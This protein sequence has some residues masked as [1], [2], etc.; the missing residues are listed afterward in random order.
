MQNE[1]KLKITDIIY[2]GL[3][4]VLYVLCY[5]LFYWMALEYQGKYIS[6]LAYYVSLQSSDERVFR[7][8]GLMYKA[9][10]RL[11]P[12][13]SVEGMVAF[14]A[15]MVVLIV[16]TN[17]AY[18]KFFSEESGAH[19]FEIQLASLLGPFMGSMYIPSLHEYF[20]RKSFASF[21]WHSPTYFAMI[22]SGTLCLLFFIKMYE[23][24]KDHISW[25]YWVLT[26]ITGTLSSH[27][28][29]SFI[30]NMIAAMIAVFLI[31][32]VKTPAKERLSTFK[33]LVIMG[34]S[35]VPAGCMVLLLFKIEFRGEGHAHRG[36]I[37][38]TFGNLLNT[39]HLA[40]TAIAGLAFPLIVWIVN[41]KLIKSKRYCMPFGIFVMGICQWAPFEETGARASHGNFDWGLNAGCYYLF[42][43][44][45]AIAINNWHDRENFMKDKPALRNL[46][47]CVLAILLIWHVGSQLVY[48]YLVYHGNHFYQ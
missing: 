26:M 38:I 27:A 34:L 32:L 14:T 11:M 36:G 3:I 22:F 10:Y 48:F 46:Y 37:D 30:L 7:F 12:G 40:I 4:S 42:L 1:S 13:H 8:V 2:I 21:A 47:F 18:I 9:I 23:S 24:S 41:Y 25:K 15:F 17:Y 31:E 39:E 35:L 5:R 19:R 29:P 20:Y 28:K 43:T 44:S 6:D 33:R 16:L 45:I